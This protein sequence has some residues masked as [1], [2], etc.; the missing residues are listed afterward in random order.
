MKEDFAA[1]IKRT[2]DGW[3]AS[4]PS[5]GLLAEAS[6]ANATVKALVEHREKLKH[7][8][9]EAGFDLPDIKVDYGVQAPCKGNIKPFA[10]RAVLVAALTAAVVLF[11]AITL[12]LVINYQFNRF[13]VV[14]ETAKTYLN[15]TTFGRALFGSLDRLAARARVMKPENVERLAVNI[16]VVKRSLEPVLRE[17]GPLTRCLVSQ[18][19]NEASNE[20]KI[21]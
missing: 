17:F 20:S 8:F 7:E 6:D 14:A 3:S 4:I 12:N 13:M 5:L 9:E 1:I 15:P 18:N 11:S 21:D 10:L 2:P 16:R 19:L